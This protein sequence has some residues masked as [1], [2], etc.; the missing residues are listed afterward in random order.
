MYMFLKGQLDQNQQ[1]SWKGFVNVICH[2]HS[3]YLNGFLSKLNVFNGLIS[4][5]DSIYRK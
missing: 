2:T 5:R 1:R 4:R 3:Q